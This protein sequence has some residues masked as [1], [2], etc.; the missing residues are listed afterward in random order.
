MSF[1]G[2]ENGPS[3]PRWVE[4]P[5]CCDWMRADSE[6]DRCPSC[7]ELQAEREVAVCADADDLGI[8][9]VGGGE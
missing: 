1:P 5:R 7:L 6:A 4:C 3:E 2:A 9:G 8:G